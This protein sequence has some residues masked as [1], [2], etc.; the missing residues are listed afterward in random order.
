[1]VVFDPLDAGAIMKAAAEMAA[2]KAEI[3]GR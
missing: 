2:A 3:Y 1:M